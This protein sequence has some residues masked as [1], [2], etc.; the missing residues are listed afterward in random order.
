M[1]MGFPYQTQ[2]FSPRAPDSDTDIYR[3]FDFDLLSPASQVVQ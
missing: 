2:Q 3:K 1:L